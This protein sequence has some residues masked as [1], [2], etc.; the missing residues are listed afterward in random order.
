MQT[1]YWPNY[2][3][4]NGTNYPPNEP[5]SQYA[6]AP[7][8]CQTADN[9]GTDPSQCLVPGYGA[10]QLFML[11]RVTGAA[12][13][14]SYPITY[15][16][17]AACEQVVFTTDL[18]DIQNSNN[19]YGRLYAWKDY[20]DFL[21]VTVSLNATGFGPAGTTPSGFGTNPG[22]FLFASPSLFSPGKP[23]GQIAVWGTFIAGLPA[24]YST[25]QMLSSQ[26]VTQQW[27]C[28]T[29]SINLRSTCDP[30]ISAYQRNMIP[31]QPGVCQPFYSGNPKDSVA[32]TDLSATD[33]LY[34]SVQFNLTRFSLG[35]QVNGGCG[36][37]ITPTS[38]AAANN[39]IIVMMRNPIVDLY[40]F[41]GSGQLPLPR[42]CAAR[43]RSP[44]P[45]SPPQP[46]LPPSPHASPQSLSPSSP[47]DL[48]VLHL[49]LQPVQPSV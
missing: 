34:F 17:K 12:A 29:V 6:I 48:P 49:L 37:V 36:S 46:P 44:T 45:P 8:I 7:A 35:N 41:P 16:Q 9:W 4:S 3:Y 14:T 23:T 31:G 24:A 11:D 5:S 21:Y 25:S 18:V 20:S 39:Q 38:P 42:N 22:Q 13:P 15:D 10:P 19:I 47:L 40:N 28:F 26:G 1:D 2:K 43:T 27:S 32:G 33:N 30:T